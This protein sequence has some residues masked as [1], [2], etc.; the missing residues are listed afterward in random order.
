MNTYTLTRASFS[1]FL[2]AST[3]LM[4]NSDEV[5]LIHWAVAQNY[6]ALI[7]DLLAE[8]NP[9][10][11][12][13]DNEGNT[14][15]HLAARN[16]NNLIL[17]VLL[18]HGA[19]INAVNNNGDT[20]LHVASRAGRTI[21]VRQLLEA[22]ALVTLPNYNGDTAWRLAARNYPNAIAELIEHNAA[23]IILRLVSHNG[24]EGRLG[25]I[26]TNNN[27][28]GTAQPLAGVPDGVLPRGVTAL[29]AQYAI[30]PGLPIQARSRPNANS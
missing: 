7:E 26:Y 4:S 12:I 23:R 5:I 1:I 15:L 29:I 17:Q 11:T 13:Q 8:Y 18:A 30:A 16:G 3:Q 27:A 21:P 19:N 14:A 24:A 22:G 6:G 10:L 28:N 2:V 9:N 20:A 25:V